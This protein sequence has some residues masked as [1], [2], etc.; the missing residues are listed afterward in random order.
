MQNKTP[1]EQ[2][3]EIEKKIEDLLLHKAQLA[4]ER[5]KYL[6]ESA[7]LTLFMALD[8]K[9]V[10]KERKQ[11]LLTRQSSLVSFACELNDTYGTQETQEFVRQAVDLLTGKE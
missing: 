7:R 5:E 8:D 9:E 10:E 2:I 11:L 6:K 1:N 3:K 4:D